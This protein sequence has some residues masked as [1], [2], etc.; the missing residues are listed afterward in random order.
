MNK[1]LREKARRIGNPAY[2][3]N[4]STC[5]TDEELDDL[6]NLILNKVKKAVANEQEWKNDRYQNSSFICRDSTIEAIDNL[7][8]KR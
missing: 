6:I 4:E 5:Y 1:D 7:R 3:D 2:R 8:G